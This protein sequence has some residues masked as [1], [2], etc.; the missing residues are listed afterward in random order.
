MQALLLGS[1]AQSQKVWIIKS[2]QVQ[3]GEKYNPT[4]PRSRCQD[5]WILK[6]K[7]YLLKFLGHFIHPPI[8]FLVGLRT[9]ASPGWEPPTVG[10]PARAD[11]GKGLGTGPLLTH[12]PALA[13]VAG[14]TWE[15]IASPLAF[16]VSVGRADGHSPFQ[17]GISFTNRLPN[18]NAGCA[19]Q[20]Q[21]FSCVRGGTWIRSEHRGPCG[22]NLP[23]GL[24]GSPH[25]RESCGPGSRAGTTLACLANAALGSALSSKWGF[26]WMWGW[27]T[28][29]SETL[30]LPFNSLTS[31]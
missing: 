1:P 9:A 8:S 2:V 21:S 23:S 28:W 26:S 7:V 22:P 16:K 14:R 17:H 30:S 12:T 6:G 18:P 27:L 5:P 24:P 29:L 13:P 3:E 15:L 4:L 31:A 11:I 25:T 10:P 20:S 19:A